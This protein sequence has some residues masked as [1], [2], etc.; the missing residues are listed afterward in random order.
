MK[1]L[2]Y[3][4]QFY[5]R[6][7][8]VERVTQ[9]LAQAWGKADCE[10]KVVC[11]TSGIAEEREAFAFEIVRFP[12]VGQ[13][14]QLLHWCDVYV[15][16]CISLKGILPWLLVRKPLVMIHHT[17]YCHPNGH[18]RPQDWLKLQITRLGR[19][20]AVSEAIAAHLPVPAQVI[21]NPY[22]EDIFYPQPEIKRDRTLIF[23]GRLVSDKG[24]D[25]LIAA[26]GRLHQQ[27]LTPD[28][29][30]I[31][32]GPERPTLEAQIDQL[33]LDE[34]VTFAGEL[35]PQEVAGRLCQHRIMVIPSRWQEPFGIVAL[36]GLACGCW[37]VGS[38]QGGLSAAIGPGGLTFTN[39]D[40]VALT[41]Q[42]TRL[43]TDP[44]Q[45]QPD[46]QAIATHLRHHQQQTVAQLY[47]DCFQQQYW[48]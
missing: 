13:L 21:E 7:G 44:P 33:N 32:T 4:P 28:L 16:S 15:Q 31:G 19:N 1:I 34:Q 24:A 27:G 2:I 46:Q 38:N 8:G 9:M 3:S 5:P 11:Q 37:L 40:V 42:L 30:L 35:P 17:W 10:V 36:E 29:T 48:R 39:G 6:L 22:A 20:I 45:W 47:L 25:L 23:V 41:A 12:T 26:L 14:L 18:L 43:L